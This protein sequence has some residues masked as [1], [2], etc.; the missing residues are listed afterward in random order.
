LKSTSILTI[1]DLLANENYTTC[2][3]NLDNAKKEV[4]VLRDKVI[5]KDLDTI[6]A[7]EQQRETLKDEIAEL[8][9]LL[10]RQE[11]IANGKKRIENLEEQ[12]SLL[13]QQ[14]AELEQKEFIIDKFHSEKIYRIEES[15]NSM[16]PTVKFKLFNEQLNG[17]TSECCDTLLNGVPFSNANNA[18]KIQA[19]IEIINVLSK[20]HNCTAP[21]FVDNAESIVNIPQTDAQL[22]KLVVSENHK[23]LTIN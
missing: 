19:G 7:L 1:E 15:I 9:K 16:F 21:I 12:S 13:A 22:I 10:Y 5:D 6:K 14:L 20:K 2:L 4:E 17:G 23:C 8:N 11:Q 18:G 3:I